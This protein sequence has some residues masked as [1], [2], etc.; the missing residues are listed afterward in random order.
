MWILKLAGI[1][2]LLSVG[3]NLLS[4]VY[5]SFFSGRESLSGFKKGYTQHYK[6]SLVIAGLIA[7]TLYLIQSPIQFIVLS[8]FVAF[9][10][11]IFIFLGNDEDDDHFSKL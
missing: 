5:F 7:T 1:L 6:K 2:I 10:S 9:I 3:I 8:F 11:S 4:F